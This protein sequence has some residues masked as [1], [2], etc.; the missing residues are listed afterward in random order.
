MSDP[1]IV[2]PLSLVGVTIGDAQ[3]QFAA[4]T[5]FQKGVGLACF[6][7]VTLGFCGFFAAAG[8]PAPAALR[9]PG[10]CSRASSRS[11]CCFWS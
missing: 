3:Q 6:G 5:P 8:D 4:S 10:W 7:A 11:R 2:G 9:P 1:R